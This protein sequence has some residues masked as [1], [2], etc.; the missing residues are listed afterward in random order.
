[1]ASTVSPFQFYIF[2]FLRV[3]VISCGIPAVLPLSSNQSS[4]QWNTYLSLGSRWYNIL[5]M[6]YTLC[7]FSYLWRTTMKTVL[8]CWCIK[9]KFYRTRSSI[10]IVKTQILILMKCRHVLAIVSWD[11]VKAFSPTD[12][13]FL[14][15]CNLTLDYANF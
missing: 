2:T 14:R 1:M 13:I 10:T 4:R 12:T 15:V 5:H 8:N 3:Y 9:H 11:Y 6:W 7:W